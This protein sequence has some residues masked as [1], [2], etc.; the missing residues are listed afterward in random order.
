MK[1][2]G[3]FIN[4]FLSL[5]LSL[6]VM[7]AAL[8]ATR[9]MSIIKVPHHSQGDTVLRH[10][11]FRPLEDTGND[12]KSCGTTAHARIDERLSKC[13]FIAVSPP[14]TH[15]KQYIQEH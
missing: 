9:N 11:L 13:P 14:T 5:S 12:T 8:T 6:P 1:Q 4:N 10:E 2:A 15:S 3:D 7:A